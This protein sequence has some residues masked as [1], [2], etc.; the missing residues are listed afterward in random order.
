V[1]LRAV[2]WRDWE[3]II[4]RDP[5]TRGKAYRTRSRYLPRVDWRG[6]YLTGRVGGFGSRDRGMQQAR[7]LLQT[8]MCTP[9][10]YHDTRC[11]QTPVRRPAATRKQLMWVLCIVNR[12]QGV[13]CAAVANERET[14]YGNT[15]RMLA[16]S[17]LVRFDAEGGV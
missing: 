14:N 1:E 17:Q 16:Q 3:C 8:N 5:I 7:L 11:R 9:R 12:K 10:L 2:G 13:L 15:R 6:W 4:P